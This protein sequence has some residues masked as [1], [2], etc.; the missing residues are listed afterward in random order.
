MT[1]FVT[2]RCNFRCHHCFY[3]RE[4][5]EDKDE[6]TLKEIGKFTK[7]LPRLLHVLLTGGDDLPPQKLV[8]V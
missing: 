7:S 3:W 2:S 5:Q 6:L 4:I 1:F 8:Q